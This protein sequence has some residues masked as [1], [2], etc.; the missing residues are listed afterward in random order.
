MIFGDRSQLAF[1]VDPVEPT[2]DRRSV[3]ARGPWA[4]LSVFLRNRCLTEAVD[5]NTDF[6][7]RSVSV[8]LFPVADWL[9]RNIRAIVFEESPAA[10]RS[11]IQLHAALERWTEAPPPAGVPEE[12]WEDSRY[13]W[14]TR[15]F[16]L[17][18]VEG[19]LLPDLAFVRSDE[20]L[21]VN[22]IAPEFAGP[23]KLQFITPPGCDAVRWPAAWN[24]L[25]RF[26]SF[27]AEE[28]RDRGLTEIPWTIE[29]TPLES[30]CRCSATE[31][32]QLVAPAGMKML[33]PLGL[34]GQEDPEKSI[35]LQVMR[36]LDLNARS[37]AA[38]TDAL[39]SLQSVTAVAAARPRRQ[40]LRSALE[41][42]TEGLRIER[43]G[44]DA[45]RALRSL[46][47]LDGDALSTPA[48]RS[49]LEEIA[50][51]IEIDAADSNNHAV[52]G[53]Q[54]DGCAG[55]V[56]IRHARTSKEWA[57][58]MEIARALAHLLLDPQT[59]H[60]I[61]G[62]ASS[63]MATGPRR[64]RSGAFAAELLCPI[65]GARSL[66]GGDDPTDAAV[67]ERVLGHFG[68]GARTAAYHL[69]NHRVLRTAE[70]RDSLIDEFA[71]ATPS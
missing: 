57:W 40:E 13:E 4:R 54:R 65:D 15:H 7:R 70:D 67:F 62:A 1:E 41:G 42:D 63:H 35:L 64:R 39:T 56:L 47:H 10:F 44:Y 48:L 61:I 11:D 46:L 45:A 37:I 43:A 33:E 30:A 27:V 17:P 21:W 60:G 22:W 14:Y 18:G 20:K 12:S 2:W 71:G 66:I 25:S 55:V 52:M 29:P 16:W 50:D 26:V 31:Y 38:A 19:C 49:R 34:A 3:S 24:G 36:D 6:V 23:R 28:M 53:S 32:L 58:R 9:V 5:S 68:I 59:P 51:V 8:P 69:W